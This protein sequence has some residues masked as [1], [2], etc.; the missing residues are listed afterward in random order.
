M[1]FIVEFLRDP[2]RTG[3]VMASSRPVVRE[4]LHDVDL[5]SARS[6]VELGAGTGVVTE[7]LARRLPPHTRLIAVELNPALAE[8]L[9]R[10][11]LG[12]QVDVVTGSA[13]Q[14]P[15]FLA[16][17][18]IG[19]VDHVISCLPWTAMDEHVRQSTIDATTSAL[20]DAGEF[21]TLL[22]AHT[23]RGRVG[24]QFEGLLRTRFTAAR[25]GETIW[26]NIPPMC[27]VRCTGPI[28][29]GGYQRLSGADQGEL[30]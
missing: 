5:S 1:S 15:D 8:R 11:R 23:I 24:R 27:V 29:S 19:E 13:E 9:R 16:E 28:A 12:S 17:R 26:A 7:E 21:R 25:R 30:A 10:R 2:L 14:L 22:C 18:G 4:L 3:A 6:V 20:G